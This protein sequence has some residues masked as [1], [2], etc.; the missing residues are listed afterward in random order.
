MPSWKSARPALR[1]NR[2]LSDNNF[3]IPRRLV[4][5]RRRGDKGGGILQPSS[6]IWPWFFKV[7]YKS[8]AFS[9]FSLSC[10]TALTA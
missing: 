6:Q 5:L 7:L 8:Y 9:G 3:P 2:T 1:G 4:R 10:T